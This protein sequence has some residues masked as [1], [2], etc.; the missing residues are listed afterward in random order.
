MLVI[1]NGAIKSGSTWLYNILFEFAKFQRPPEHYLTEGSR[2]RTKNPCIQPEMLK[3]F[4][5]S[6]NIA[7]IDFLSKNH[8]GQPTHRDVLLRSEHVY[9]F[10]IERN[11]RD[12][13]VSSY[14]DECNR[15]GYNGGFV[16]Y[17]WESGRYIAD[18]VIRYHDLWRNSGPRFCM[19]SYEK[20]H[21]DFSSEV[22][23]MASALGLS[24]DRA[25]IKDLR[26]KTSMG[27]LR[28]RYEDESLYQADKFFRKGI[29][30]D[31]E[32][33]FDA[34]MRKDIGAIE[35]RGVRALD[36]RL[37]TKRMRSVVQRMLIRGN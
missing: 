32:N 8:I 19:V 3:T 6:E 13:T 28:K 29:V 24:L 37:L 5:A 14:Y 9:V 36:R 23:R 20:L 31:W 30:G 34:S 2:K 10:D 27:A 17:Y 22:A 26:E 21:S 7:S 12:M 16:D 25:A 33:H 1:C 11:V 35:M 4:I 15:N 18:E